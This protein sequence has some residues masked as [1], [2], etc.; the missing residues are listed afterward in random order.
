M[1]VFFSGEATDLANFAADVGTDRA[2]GQFEDY[3]YENVAY[4]RDAML[5]MD[6]GFPAIT[7]ERNVAESPALDGL[8]ATVTVDGDVGAVTVLDA[9]IAFEIGGLSVASKIA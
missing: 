5:L 8:G 3:P 2:R 6:G 7:I 4:G 9:T 1:D